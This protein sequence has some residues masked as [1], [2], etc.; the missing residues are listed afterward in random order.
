M[1]HDRSPIITPSPIAGWHDGLLLGYGPMDRVHEEFVGLIAE[2][3]HASRASADVE[4][5]LGALAAH[6]RDHF[7]ME[8]AW[9]VESDFPARDCHIAEH[10][11]VLRSIDGVRQRVAQGERA[12]TQALARELAVWFPAHC[13]YL[14]AALAH[15]LCKRRFGAKPVVMRRQLHTT[16]A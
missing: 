6:A 7:D 16:A 11:A 8:N 13:D 12:P 2:F 9:M 15:W 14:D 5:A 1:F 4:L 10:D 3:E